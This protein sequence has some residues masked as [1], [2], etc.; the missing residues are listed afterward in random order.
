MCVS[1]RWADL[2]WG[3]DEMCGGVLLDQSQG[4]SPGLRLQWGLNCATGQAGLFERGRFWE[5]QQPELENGWEIPV[6]SCSGSKGALGHH[7]ALGSP[8]HHFRRI[9][10]QLLHL[11]CF[12]TCSGAHIQDWSLS[13]LTLT[14]E[15]HILE[16]YFFLSIS[17]IVPSGYTETLHF[18]RQGGEGRFAH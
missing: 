16:V 18:S 9:T 2:G 5:M 10:F 15:N 11:Y 13:S 12:C 14:R 1:G 3:G 17:L 4:E 8:S 7:R 6:H